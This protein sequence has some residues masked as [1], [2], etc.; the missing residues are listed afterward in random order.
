[1]DYRMQKKDYLIALAMTVL[2]A[3]IAFINL[4]SMSAPTNG[5]TPDSER[6]S[7]IVFFEEKTEID[8]I[9]YYIGIGDDWYSAG[10]LDLEYLD[11]NNRFVELCSLEKPDNRVFKWLHKEV[12]VTTSAI[13]LT[14]AK[15]YN[16]DSNV[17]G[18][19]GEILEVAFFSGD[20][21]T[22]IAIDRIEVLD[23][24]SKEMEMLFDEQ[25]IAVYT[26][27]FMNSTYFDEIYFPRTAFE[28]MEGMEPFENTHPP[29]GKTL[30]MFSYKIFGV[31]AFAWRFMGTLF[32]ILMIPLMYIF[33][34]W[35]FGKTFLAFTTAFLLMFDFM[36]FVQT[37]IGTVDGFLVFF[38]IVSYMFMYKYFSTKSYEK[39]FWKSL[40]PL[41]FSGIFFGLG[42]SVKW[43]GIFSGA[44]LAVLFFL[45]RILEY[46]DYRNGKTDVRFFKT[47]FIWGTMGMCVIFFIVIPIVVYTISY[48]PYFNATATEGWFGDLIASQK[49][50]Y[51]YHSGVTSEHPYASVWWQW[52][53]MVKPVYY[54]LSPVLEDGKWGSIASFGNPAVWW[55]GLVTLFWTAWV[56]ISKKDKRAFVIFAGYLSILLPWAFSPRKITFLYHYFAC[57]PFLILSISY[58]FEH[59]LG[60]YRKA[61]RGIYIF[62]GIV[63]LLFIGFYPVL[64]GLIVPSWYTESMRWLPSWFF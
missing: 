31:N 13:R 49:H 53:F 9:T 47:K 59:L 30:I 41:I 11:E 5:Y 33:G 3:I 15:Y 22:P 29:L 56:A 36:H 35:V 25:D 62:L 51:N 57:I 37:R 50:M 7:I 14:T 61:K 63:V 8:W 23:E 6:R 24:E 32:G 18:I 45:S 44:G 2:Y 46:K 38:I 39:G 4:G 54:Y 28:Y 19:K 1:M 52:P 12:D 21:E 10:Q 58:I 48:I 64:T 17:S 42:I 27:S 60:K 40:V 34:K 55:G 16:P 26:P 20:N 43:I